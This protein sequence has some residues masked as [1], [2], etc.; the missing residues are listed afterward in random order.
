MRNGFLCCAAL[1]LGGAAAH[2]QQMPFYG[3]NPGYPAYPGYGPPAYPTAVAPHPMPPYYPAVY[4]GPVAPSPALTGGGSA[5]VPYPM[6]PALPTMPPAQPVSAPAAPPAATATAAQPPGDKEAIQAPKQTAPSTTNGTSGTVISETIV[7]YDP[8]HMTLPAEPQAVLVGGPPGGPVGAAAFGPIGPQHEHVY[9]YGDY[10]LAWFRTSTL[11]TPL[12]TLG[13]RL[14]PIPGAIGQP[15]TS[16]LF[17]QNNTDFN[18]LHGFRTGIGFYLDHDNH[19]SVDLNGLI[20]FR[21]HERFSAASDPTGN[22]ILARPALNVA[23]VPATEASYL[24]SFPGVLAGAVNVDARSELYGGEGNFRWHN[25]CSPRLRWETLLGAR[26]L[27]LDESLAVTD[28]LNPLVGNAITFNGAF[29]PAGSILTDFDR[30]RTSNTFYGVNLGGQLRYQANWC[31]IDLYGKAALGA[32]R[33]RVDISGNTTLAAP[34]L[35]TQVAS[36]GILTQPSNIGTQHRTV[37]GIVPEFGINFGIDATEHL[38]IRCGYSMLFWNRVVRP[39]NQI[40][41]AVNPGQVPSDQAF[42]LVAGPARP[43]FQFNDELFWMQAFNLGL[44]LHY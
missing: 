30:W 25:C 24:V 37:F 2:A 44:E 22:P 34:G 33:E 5:F 10:L 9:I 41:R 27:H 36:G 4:P 28:T 17:G 32:T 26:V 39:G 16:V 13:S 15:G 23:T 35:A 21:D 38:R 40:D 20:V 31:V 12:V 11:S 3:G 7:P 42:G 43:A 18:P 8:T 6:A 19:Y 29:V 1:L 14:D